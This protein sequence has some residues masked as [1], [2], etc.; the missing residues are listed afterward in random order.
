MDL[1]WSR[2]LKKNFFAIFVF[3]F[4]TVASMLPAPPLTFSS[5]ETFGSFC[6]GEIFPY[7]PMPPLNYPSPGGCRLCEPYEGSPLQLDMEPK[8]PELRMPPMG[9]R[10]H[11]HLKQHHK[12]QLKTGPAPPQMACPKTSR[13]QIP[14]P[15]FFLK[16]EPHSFQLSGE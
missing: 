6:R 16:L 13:S 4:V 14:F 11:Q 1:L 2:H 9:P 3:V 12:Q 8:C 15:P 7:T 10:R 5:I